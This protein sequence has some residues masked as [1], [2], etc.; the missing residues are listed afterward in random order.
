MTIKSQPYGFYT[1]IW[2]FS[3]I[4][5][6][7]VNAAKKLDLILLLIIDVFVYQCRANNIKMQQSHQQQLLSHV[8][9]N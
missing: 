8:H 3:S 6:P 4:A 9:I 7:Y 2:V 1:A 5:Q